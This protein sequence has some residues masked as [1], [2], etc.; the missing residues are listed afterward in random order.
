MPGRGG[1]GVL[2]ILGLII[3]FSNFD[4]FAG[5]Q[6]ESPVA[7]SPHSSASFLPFE[8]TSNNSFPHIHLNGE[9]GVAVFDTGV[10]GKF[11][12]DEFRVD[13]MKLFVDAQVW[14]DI[15]AFAEINLATRESEDNLNIGELYVDFENVSKLWGVE[16]VLNVRFG[17]FDIPFGEE[18]QRRDA[19]D[20][21][22]ISHSLSDLWGVDEGIQIY[23]TADKFQYSFAVQNGGTPKFRD[24]NADKSITG[25]LRFDANHRFHVSLSAMRTGD[26]DTAGDQL[27]EMWFGNGFIRS[28]NSAD[29]FHANFFEGDA[30]LK[31][32]EAHVLFNAGLV[33]YGDNGPEENERD[34]SYYQVEGFKTLLSKN[35]GRLYICA[36]YSRI[37]CEKGCPLVGHGDFAMFFFDNANLTKNLWRFSIGPGFRIANNA[38]IKA[39]YTVERGDQI[40]GDVREDENFWGAEAAFKF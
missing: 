21:P 9:G 6:L 1:S 15:Y 8:I 23:G 28:L 24:F 14:K 13:E 39:E 31:W 36:R 25:R 19:I 20:N 35:E 33:N 16:D 30:E 29:T 40:N 17:R 11:P 10:E 18:Y 4:L 27:S 26:L 2:A 37:D 12:N 7:P 38:V 5:E 34:A 3:L 22:L 32:K